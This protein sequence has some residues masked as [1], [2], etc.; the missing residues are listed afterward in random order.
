MSDLIW[1]MLMVFAGGGIGASS[2]FLLEDTFK[3]SVGTWLIN[4]IGCLLM[5]FMFGWL[6]V[7]TMAEGRK[8]TLYLLTMSGF[9]GG[10][11]TF[12]HF[13]LI[14]VNY[15]RGGEPGWALGYLLVTVASGLVCCLA[16]IF[17]GAKAAHL[18]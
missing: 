13:I 2:R 7:S 12:S 3:S 4:T 14:A 9:V 15:F 16:G 1:K 5:G 8:A 11:S 18:Y 17:L 6:T 10:F